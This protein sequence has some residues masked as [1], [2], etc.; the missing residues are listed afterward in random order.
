MAQG[1]IVPLEGGQSIDDAAEEHFVILLRRCFFQD[2]KTNERGDIDSIKIHDLMHDVAQ[3]VGK[4]EARVVTSMTDKMGDKI[5]HV[6]CVGDICPETI[7]SCS[8]K[9]RSYICNVSKKPSVDTLIDKW[10]CLRAL[11]LSGSHIKILPDSIGKLLH[12]RNSSDVD[13]LK[14]L[15]ALKPLINLKGSIRIAIGEYYTNR[16]VEGMN[17]GV[18]GGYLKSMKYLT[19]VDIDFSDKQGGCVRHEAVLEVLEPPSKLKGFCLSDYQGTIIPKWGTAESNW[20]VSLSRLVNIRFHGCTN[21]TEMPVL[22]K[23]PHLKSL[24]LE[25]LDSLEYMENT[26]GSMS[27]YGEETA[28]LA[29]FFPSLTKLIFRSM[30][31]LKGWRKEEP[32]ADDNHGL[33]SRWRFPSVSILDIYNC[34]N[35]TL[36]P[37]C[38][39]LEK[40]TFLTSSKN[41][42]ILK[43]ADDTSVSAKFWYL[44]TDNASIL[45][46]V[47]TNSLTSLWITEGR[48]Q[49]RENESEVGEAFQRCASSL[50]SL[51]IDEINR[52]KRLAGGTGLQHFSALEEIKLGRSN[53]LYGSEVYE[54]DDNMML[55]KSFPQ[56]LR[57]LY[58]HRFEWTSL[59][60]GMQYLTS[61]KALTIYKC[62]K[63]TA[64]PEWISSLSS[65]QSLVILDCCA[66]KSI[67]EAMRT[68]TSLQRLS[69]E[70]CRNLLKRCKEPDGE[71][72]PK[73]Q[74]IPQICARVRKGHFSKQDDLAGLTE[75]GW[76]FGNDNFT[77]ALAASFRTSRFGEGNTS[78]H[79]GDP[80]KLT[81]KTT[82][83]QP[84]GWA[85]F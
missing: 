47:P 85:G 69:I 52:L 60:K 62:T 38:P 29:T 11:D 12:L 67:P 21:L 25:Y 9:I 55:W 63:L 8:N 37:H 74:H 7:S 59:P 44:H 49:E 40:L 30:Y 26:S 72:R 48:D 65:L 45:K 10:L 2:V 78:Q 18:E 36:I 46:S 20:A 76:G 41:F 31:K 43:T 51:T 5:R 13:E 42:Q 6:Q 35:L 3:E 58:L 75:D 84:V 77:A 68:L 54:E 4:E 23:M 61:L 80:N 79:I 70:R 17:N 66:L 34:P 27:N 64:L 16:K 14:A 33:N 53:F 56:S 83:S 39:N 1:Y 81:S 57:S 82:A 71:D 50:Q 24:V 28:E 32:S 22:S 73:I 19:S 15:K